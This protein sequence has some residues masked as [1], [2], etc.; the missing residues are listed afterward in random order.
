MKFV[1]YH[2]STAKEPK[3]TFNQ[4]W[5][6]LTGF[7]PSPKS[8]WSCIHVNN[9]QNYTLYINLHI[10]LNI[11]CKTTLNIKETRKSIKSL[12]R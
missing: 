11:L 2:S 12:R 4:N 1:I 3:N 8:F 10:L 9:C 6:V 5:S 7:Y